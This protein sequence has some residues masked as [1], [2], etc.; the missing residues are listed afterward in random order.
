MN[1]ITDNLCNKCVLEY[2]LEYV[3]LTRWNKTASTISFPFISS[4]FW[5][6]HVI[7]E[8]IVE[9]VFFHLTWNTSLISIWLF[10]S[11]Q[12]MKPRVLYSIYCQRQTRIETFRFYWLCYL[13]D[14]AWQLYQYTLL[15]HPMTVLATFNTISLGDATAD[16]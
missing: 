4:T 11:R 10:S 14:E 16:L 9:I 2:L 6:I 15:W 13:N 12:R 7:L 5:K 3:C 1:M 8:I